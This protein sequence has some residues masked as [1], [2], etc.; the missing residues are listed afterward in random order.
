MFRGTNFT[1]SNESF[2]PIE[3]EMQIAARLWTYF[4]NHGCKN[5]ND[6]A[7]E[8]HSFACDIYEEKVG[9]MPRDFDGH[10]RNFEGLS[11]EEKGVWMM[12]AVTAD[13]YGEWAENAF[14][15]VQMS[16]SFAAMLMATHISLK[17]LEHVTAPWP[18]FAIEIPDKLLPIQSR[19]VD[20]CV[21]RVFV[22]DHFMPPSCPER[23]WTFCLQGQ[24][25]E[26]FRA[27]T[28]LNLVTDKGDHTPAPLMRLNDPNRL[29]PR[30]APLVEED[31]A[32]WT[33]DESDQE[34][35][36]ALLVTR[37]V[38]GVCVMMTE[39]ANYT[40]KRIK[41]DKKLGQYADPLRKAYEQRQSKL[42]EARVYLLGKPV[43]I[44]FRQAV[45]AFVEG[46][47]RGPMTVQRLVAGHH[48]HQP[49]GP[50]SSLRK[51]IFIEPYWQG[52][53]DSPIVVRPHVG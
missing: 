34:D 5:R 48:K 36:I 47:S 21:T 3:E 53:S 41:L 23:W 33:N 38:I 11:R 1:E 52:P 30:D 50:N 51:W 12:Q 8:A 40:E 32:F 25:I 27:D 18:C 9:P 31:E 4:Q 14:P 7:L 39:R 6:R 43:K 37:L 26:M 22:N 10:S 49:Y 20:S 35:R 28:L 13:W 45:K 16:H 29:D 15:R 24:R 42:P 44:D 17:E 19:G 46:R 2:K